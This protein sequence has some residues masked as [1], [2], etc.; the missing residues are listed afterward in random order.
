MVPQLNCVA[1]NLNK[2]DIRSNDPLT[3]Y[4]HF[5]AP[6]L[7]EILDPFLDIILGGHFLIKFNDF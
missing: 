1:I 6:I 2:N 5:I 3:I 4:N 7:S